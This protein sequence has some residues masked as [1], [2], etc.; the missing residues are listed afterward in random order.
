MT[1]NTGPQPRIKRPEN[2]N[3]EKAETVVKKLLQENKEWL[4]E[5]AD[6]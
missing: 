3:M 6:K 2:M 1:A 4:K 5:M